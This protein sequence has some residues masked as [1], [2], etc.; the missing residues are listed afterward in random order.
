MTILA[1][2]GFGLLVLVD[3]DAFL[4]DSPA[5]ATLVVWATAHA[6]GSLVGACGLPPLLGMLMSGIAL[7]N[8]G[9]VVDG[10]TEGWSAAIR[11][12]GLSVILMR[13]GLELDFA[14]FKRVGPAAARLTAMPGITEA[15]S[16]GLFSMLLFN[17]T[18]KAIWLGLTMGFI[19]AAVSPAV[20]VIGMFEL[21]R[22]GYGVAKGI[23]SLV[24]AAASFDDVLAISGFSICMGLAVPHGSL[25]WTI[26]H[27]P[28]NLV[29]GMLGG[30]LGGA[31][32][33]VTTLWN[34]RWKRSASTFV[35]GMIIMFM[36]K[37]YHFTG[38][39][40]MGSLITGIFAAMGWQ[41]GWGEKRGLS[42]GP[43]EVYS[44]DVEHDLAVFWKV[45]AQPL[46][47]G[48]IG[49]AIDFDTLNASTLPRAV[50]IVLIGLCGRLPAAYAAVGRAG[51]NHIERLYIALSWVPKATVQAALGSV[52]LDIVREYMY[53]DGGSSCTEHEDAA[54]SAECDQYERW[55]NEILTTAV[56][57][58][59][60]TAPV[61]LL[62]I[63]G[64]GP[65]W[66]EREETHSESASLKGSCDNLETLDQHQGAGRKDR[67]GNGS[68][69]S[70]GGGANVEMGEICVEISDG[71]DRIERAPGEDESMRGFAPLTRSVM[72]RVPRRHRRSS[73]KAIQLAR[74]LQREQHQHGHT[75]HAGQMARAF[76]RSKS[77]GDE[78]DDGEGG[79]RTGLG[80]R[81]GGGGGRRRSSLT[82]LM[83]DMTTQL[84]EL[85]MIAAFMELQ[86]GVPDSQV[87]RMKSNIEDIKQN[88]RTMSQR[89][90]VHDEMS[91]RQFFKLAHPVGGMRGRRAGDGA[92]MR[93][94]L[95]MHAGSDA[96]RSDAT[97]NVGTTR[98]R[99]ASSS[100]GDRAAAAA[101][102]RQSIDVDP[103]LST[104]SAIS[105]LSDQMETESDQ[106]GSG[107]FSR[108]GGWRP[109]AR[110]GRSPSFLALEHRLERA[111][112]IA[113]AEAEEAEAAVAQAQA[114]SAAEERLKTRR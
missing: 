90:T 54:D 100:G 37:K 7:K 104:S 67:T 103:R 96:E 27:G 2:L 81:R 1:A 105:E 45:V 75:V 88:L 68:F 59:I 48:V 114:A 46:L 97:E 55:G 112:E 94:S 22:K 9:G 76:N 35:V 10:L 56:L 43:M 89:P 92:R 80:G 109:L 62:L 4:P 77:S 69:P 110:S 32:L 41:N 42:N 98:L 57:S 24:V 12:M 19:L 28:L 111:A 47:F 16:I 52:P 58:I 101:R 36:G 72:R 40:A 106:E 8:I 61:G 65:R 3:K 86:P 18:G 20:V 85:Q 63:N 64:L 74:Q 53:P 13:S 82:P 29:F 87:E 113:R 51:L 102:M 25:A 39:G 17:M 26:A 107:R 6:A 50:G 14:A 15:V 30:L 38:A 49:A 21:Q 108:A 99:R 66:L 91:T 79:G 44:H 83:R 23:P 73:I 34:S 78:S 84:S 31:L 5:F 71:N 11:A 95:T 60:M 93:A 70:A 33:S